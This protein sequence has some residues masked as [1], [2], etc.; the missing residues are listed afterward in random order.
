MT[1]L[2]YANICADMMRSV[3]KEPFK[4]KAATRQTIYFRSSTWADGKQGPSGA[5]RAAAA[6]ASCSRSAS[7]NGCSTAAAQRWWLQQQQRRTCEL[8]Q[9]Q[10]RQQQLGTCLAAALLLVLAVVRQCWRG[11]RLPAGRCSCR[12]R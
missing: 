1:Y 6:A 2:R 10:Q 8:A 9:Q 12:R 11:W 4:S 5:G 7:S 3:L